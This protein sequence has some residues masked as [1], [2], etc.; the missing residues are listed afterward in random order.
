LKLI[1]KDTKRTD[2]YLDAR[3]ALAYGLID[4]VVESVEVRPS[5]P[6]NAAVVPPEIQP[7]LTPE[8]AAAPKS[9]P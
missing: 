8:A 9:E 1:I 2:F 6:I 4:A 3:R 5:M 7:I